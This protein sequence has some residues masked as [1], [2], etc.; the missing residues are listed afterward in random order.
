MVVQIM[1]G[2]VAR[3]TFTIIRLSEESLSSGN[4]LRKI[5]SFLPVISVLE[6]NQ[7]NVNDISGRELICM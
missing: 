1:H 6:N 3:K 5:Q 7:N 4:V 2:S